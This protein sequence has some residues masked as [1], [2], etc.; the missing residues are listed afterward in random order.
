MYVHGLD[1]G[2]QSDYTAHVIIE[3]R[4]QEPRGLVR[5]ALDGE[6]VH[7]M[8]HAERYRGVP[9][10]EV[11]RRVKRR[12]EFIREHDRRHGRRDQDQVLAVDRGE[13]GKA[14]V[15]MLREARLDVD[16]LLAVQITGGTATTFGD[17]YVGVPKR[18]LVSVVMRTAAEGR[19]RIA[20]ELA[21]AKMIQ[22]ELRTFRAKLTAAG[23]D[24]FEAARHK[25]HD[26]LVLATSLALWT[27]ERMAGPRFSGS[28]AVSWG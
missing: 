14:V 22:G 7:L 26:D 2:Q 18:D 24:T 27:G 8:I 11:V 13:V 23:N 10:P 12:I 6:L 5:H 1:L 21:L 9:Y 16:D 17:G 25:D 20:A 19:L 15:D 4:V 28:V 3:A